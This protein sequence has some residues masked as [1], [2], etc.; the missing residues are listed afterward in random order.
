MDLNSSY[1]YTC[2]KL[3]FYTLIKLKQKI[4]QTYCVLIP[5]VNKSYTNKTP[6]ISST[7]A[8]ISMQKLLL[9]L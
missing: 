1:I 7:N 9:L 2:Y 8:H 6:Q 4:L 3:C 5:S